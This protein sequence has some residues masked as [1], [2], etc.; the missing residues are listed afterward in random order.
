MGGIEMISAHENSVYIE[1]LFHMD[2]FNGQR[3][4]LLF[5]FIIIPELF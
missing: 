5:D 2:E 1:L 4:R 3:R